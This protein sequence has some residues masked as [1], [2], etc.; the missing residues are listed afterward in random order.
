MRFGPERTYA[1][2]FYSFE[3]WSWRLKYILVLNDF[4]PRG[5]QSFALE[6]RP[7]SGVAQ[8]CTALLSRVLTHGRETENSSNYHEQWSWD[9]CENRCNRRRR[10]SDLQGRVLDIVS[11]N[12]GRKVRDTQSEYYGRPRDSASP[13]LDKM[14][15][16]PECKETGE[17]QSLVT[18]SIIVEIRVAVNQGG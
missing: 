1:R 11:K 12:N 5:G 18:V 7:Q 13:V 6:A 15:S 2:A 9:Y 3:I 17:K 4:W 10:R 16:T 8:D 14:A